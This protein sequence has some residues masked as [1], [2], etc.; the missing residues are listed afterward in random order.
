MLKQA[1]TRVLFGAAVAALVVAMGGAVSFAVAGT[2][3]F[4]P[5][6]P[7]ASSGIVTGSMRI[8]NRAVSSTTVTIK[9]RD[10]AGAAG[11]HPFMSNSIPGYGSIRITTG[12]L[13]SG[14]ES[15]ATNGLGSGSGTWALTIESSGDVAVVPFIGN[16]LSAS[17]LPVEE[18]EEQG[19]N[20]N[21]MYLTLSTTGTWF[22]QGHLYYPVADNWDS[23][24]AILLRP[25]STGAYMAVREDSWTGADEDGPTP[26]DGYE[27]NEPFIVVMSAGPLHTRSGGLV[28]DRRFYHTIRTP[29][30][31]STTYRTMMRCR[32]GSG[33]TA[34]YSEVVE[35]CQRVRPGVRPSAAPACP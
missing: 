15:G 9:G 31:D 14:G 6:F 17:A 7:A 16:G 4:V 20:I 19:I 32:R 35:A 13:E 22:V 30:T 25:S 24:Q 28:E 5:Y 11:A 29:R 10:S 3:L 23:C 34:T 12:Q 18:V 8:V 21:R 2:K 26:D 33:A 27:S 1:L